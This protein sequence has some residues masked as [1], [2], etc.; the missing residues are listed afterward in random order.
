[1]ERIKNDPADEVKVSF[2]DLPLWIKV[3][4]IATLAVSALAVWKLL[5]FFAG[6]IR[7]KLENRNRK[8]ILE[9][10]VKNPGVSMRDLERHLKI[11]RSTLRHHIEILESKGHIITIKAG[12][13]RLVYPLEYFIFNGRDIDRKIVLRSDARKRILDVLSRNGGMRICELANELRMNY[14]TLHYHVA[15]LQRVGLVEFDGQSVWAGES[16]GDGKQ[17]LKP[18]SQ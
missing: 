13:E 14:K 1:M 15:V 7:V 18:L 16:S 12:K 9:F 6:K 5:P 8:R 3:H 11:N 17:H 2:W 10:I 4:H